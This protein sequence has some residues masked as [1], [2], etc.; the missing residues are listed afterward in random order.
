MYKI[1]SLAGTFILFCFTSNSQNIGIGTS[2]PNNSAILDVSATSKGLLIPRVNLISFTDVVTV[3]NPA[4]GLLVY[5]TNA[6]MANGELP[7]S[8]KTGFYVWLGAP[9][10]WKKMVSMLDLY[11]SNTNDAFLLGG[12]NIP[13]YDTVKLG[14]TNN[15]PLFFI[16]NNNFVGRLDTSGSVAFGR[17]ALK[18][19]D[20]G[21][22]NIG[23]GQ[24]A[25]ELNGFNVFSADG[26]DS[27]IAI[28]D[29][30]M[31]NGQ[32]IDNNIALGYSALRNAGPTAVNDNIAIGNYSLET[33][34]YRNNIA[35]GNSSGRN[36]NG[37]IGNIIIG[38]EALKNSVDGDYNV[39]I[40]HQSMF[41][42]NGNP[43][44]NV[45]IG[46]FSLYNNINGVKNIAIGT[47]ALQRSTKSNNL[48][49]G[50]SALFYNGPAI[51]T[52][53]QGINN[54]AIG[55]N[56]F[57]NSTSASNSV[58]LGYRAMQTS[59]GDNNIAI[60]TNAMQSTIYTTN[61]STAIGND[62]FKYGGSSDVVAVGDSALHNNNLRDTLISSPTGNTA[63][64]SKSLLENIFGYNNTAVGRYSLQ[65]NVDGNDN[66]AIGTDALLSNTRSFNTA[67]GSNALRFNTGGDRNVALGSYALR[68][69]IDGNGNI[70]IGNAAL[71]NLENNINNL[72]AIGDSA[73]FS[74]F[75]TSG[76][77]GKGN[78]AVGAKS[79]RTNLYGHSNLG[80]GR[81]ALYNNQNSDYNLA[82]GDSAMYLN[83]GGEGNTAIGALAL[84]D[85]VSGDYNTSVGTSTLKNNTASG[86]TAVGY[87]SGF[88]NTTGTYNTA[89][90]N[91]ALRRNTTGSRNTAIGTF[92]MDSTTAADD[93][94]I[95][96][97]GALR[98]NKTGDRNTAL[99]SFTL[100]NNTTGI[101]NVAIGYDA[102]GA[103]TTGSSNIAIGS[104]ALENAITGQTNIAIGVNALA[105]NLTGDGNTAVGDGADVT[106]SLNNVSLFG[107]GSFA[108]QSNMVVLGNTAVSKWALG[109]SNVI[110][111]AALQ[112]GSTAT[113]GNAA[114]LSVGGTW[115]NASDINLK[116]NIEVVDGNS[117]LNKIAN[118]SI[119]KWRYKGT[120]EYH[121]G[122]MAQDFKAAFDLG[123]DDKSI[124][125][126][127]PSGVSLIAVQELLKEIEQ[128]KK[129]IEVLEKK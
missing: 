21:K 105:T 106:S 56:A 68:S 92:A 23:I 113:N 74:N 44:R 7:S 75:G 82:I 107:S 53:T 65:K 120:N 121:I 88:R 57:V 104:F 118:L 29:K 10:Y 16:V 47:D 71:Y 117:I 64:G 24:N 97:Y 36:L 125:T 69:N 27:N 49:I 78:I 39:A 102:L 8:T 5:N 129:R 4:V 85:N 70:A 126:I 43:L 76:E 114:Y 109:R 77:D 110:V 99:G 123:N 15:R 28:G 14:T 51:T 101:V 94:T 89:V 124:S 35:V 87:N 61:R 62:A 103:N 63:I 84:N 80:I 95:V 52:S 59:S 96:G 46:A 54:V 42:G 30:A 32:G 98:K 17:D 67:V 116:E 73:L 3:P 37:S 22:R 79:L 55:N 9:N 93:N 45:G 119:T 60:G 11:E 127:D 2:S 41:L 66:T 100:Y 86:N 48:A 111:G 38:H 72:V 128:L 83:N 90:G 81:L 1:L 34:P 91:L 6:A 40:G 25:L 20:A 50:D 112:V 12:N 33:D 31:Q 26:L 13:N 18:N 122:P 108:S 19:N 115:T 58:A